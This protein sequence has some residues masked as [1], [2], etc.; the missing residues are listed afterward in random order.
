[1]PNHLISV[2]TTEQAR[3]LSDTVQQANSLHSTLRRYLRLRGAGVVLTLRAALDQVA[4]GQPLPDV[5]DR[6]ELQLPAS[7]LDEI[8]ALT[9]A[10]LHQI[11]GLL[12]PA[13]VRAI[14]HSNTKR[15]EKR[16]TGRSARSW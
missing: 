1:M 16:R 9:V 10:D 14:C 7:A 13:T 5:H 12:S 3:H 15:L 2:P 4:A 6:C 11:W 8:R